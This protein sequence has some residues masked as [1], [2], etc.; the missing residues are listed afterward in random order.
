MGLKEWTNAHTDCK[1]AILIN[2]NS[3]P[4]RE[5]LEKINTGK[6]AEAAKN[7]NAFGSL[8]SGGGMYDEK[9]N[10]VPRPDTDALP[11]FDPENAQ[12]FFDMTIG[13]GE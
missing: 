12:V 11:A 9:E 6:K 8:F 4:Y 3:K 2:P 5:M 10:F 7:K 13:S 1:A